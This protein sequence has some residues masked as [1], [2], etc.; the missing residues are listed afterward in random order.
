MRNWEKRLQSAPFTIEALTKTGTGD[1]EVYA[2]TCRIAL[3]NWA[4]RL[5]HGDRFGLTD[6]QWA[7]PEDAIAAWR[8]ALEYW[9]SKVK[10]GEEKTS[11]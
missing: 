6:H 2:K 1:P 10:D 7:G 5:V 8:E 4:L 3:R 11:V 9:E